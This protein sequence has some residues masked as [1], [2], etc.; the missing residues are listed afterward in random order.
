M[1]IFRTIGLVLLTGCA[2]PD[3][4]YHWE[5]TGPALPMELVRTSQANVQGL[6]CNTDINVWACTV[7]TETTCRVYTS[8][9]QLPKATLNHEKK[10]CDGYSHQ[11]LN[12]IEPSKQMCLTEAQIWRDK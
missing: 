9:E 1:G 6:C 10:H 7:R 4:V 5:K 3:Y 12:P 2:T 8:W 11:V